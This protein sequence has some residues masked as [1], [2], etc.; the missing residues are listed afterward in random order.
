MML[1]TE[2]SFRDFMRSTQSPCKMFMFTDFIVYGS[3]HVFQNMSSKES[4]F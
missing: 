1:P 2:F 4:S 3:P